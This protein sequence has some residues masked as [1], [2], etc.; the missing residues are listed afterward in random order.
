MLLK[1]HVRVTSALGLPGSVVGNVMVFLCSLR[2]VF[3][4]CHL[5][6]AAHMKENIR[7]HLADVSGT[8]GV[9]SYR[10]HIYPG[11]QRLF[12]KKTSYSGITSDDM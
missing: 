11:S 6:M 5:G 10:D 3:L 7:P 8:N 1:N 2:D 4:I 9:S 12:N